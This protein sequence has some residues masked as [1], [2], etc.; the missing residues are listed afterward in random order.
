MIGTSLNQYRVIASIGMGEL[1]RARDTRL[2]RQVALK[3]LPKE[4]IADADRLRRFEQEA[5]TLAALN[6]PKVAIVRGDLHE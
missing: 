3:L 1:F 2:N 4:F 6:H 5:K